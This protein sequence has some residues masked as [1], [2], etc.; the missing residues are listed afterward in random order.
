M[1]LQGTKA[2]SVLVEKEA[3]PAFAFKITQWRT[4]ITGQKN[5]TASAE[6]RLCPWLF[7]VSQAR[8]GTTRITLP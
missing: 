1:Y 2:G 7:M 5:N 6:E 4:F 8:G 3:E